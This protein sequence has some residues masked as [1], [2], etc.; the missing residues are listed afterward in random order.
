MKPILLRLYPFALAVLFSACFVGCGKAAPTVSATQKTMVSAEKTSFDEVTSQLDPGGSLYLYLSTEQLLSGVSQ[1][2]AGW[3]SALEMMPESKPGD[4]ENVKKVFELL[5]HLVKDSGIEE[6]SGVGMSS[7]ATAPGF[8]HGKLL[9]HH[10]K[11]N[12]SGLLWNLCEPKPHALD[13]LELLP[14]STVLATCSDLD[15]AK[16]WAFIRKEVDDC[17]LPEAQRALD[18][19]PDRFEKKTGFQWDKTLASLGGEY[20]FAITL[21]DTRMVTLP[22]PGT[23]MQVPEPAIMIVAKV[24][25]DLIFD[26]IDQALSKMGQQVTSVDKPNLKMRTL[27][28]PIPLPFQVRPSIARSG[29]YLFIASNDALIQEALAVKSGQRPGLKSTDEFQK[30]AKDIPDKGN[31]FTFL[32]QRFGKTFMEVEKQALA[33]MPAAQ[34]KVLD[35]LMQSNK[36]AFTYSVAAITDQGWFT[37]ANGNQHPAKLFIA[38]AV[39]PVA[40]MSAVALPAFAKARNTAQKNQCIGNLRQI[41]AA[42]QKWALEKNKKQDDVPTEDDLAPYLTNGKMPSCPVGGSYT[43]NRVGD[44]AECSK[45]GHTLPE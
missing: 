6:V 25:N 14:S 35:A 12:G 33:K 28:L 2:L 40:I 34:S 15:I 21:D 4:R 7:I 19:L 9:L 37:V 29:D 10:Y 44:K 17:D 43:I 42:K 38:G 32:S 18:S 30:M 31:Q 5:T 45:S 16:L 36:V 11:G 20:E 24:K 22:I 1:K 8:Y 13:G 39:A 23:A 26:R 27:L 3:Q 41:E